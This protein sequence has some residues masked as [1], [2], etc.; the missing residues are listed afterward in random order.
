MRLPASCFQVPG[1]EVIPTI[2]FL[3]AQPC[4][5]FYCPQKSDSSFLFFCQAE[6]ITPIRNCSVDTELMDRVISLEQEFCI[7]QISIAVNGTSASP[8]L[9]DST[10]Q[11]IGTFE[12]QDD[13]SL[14]IAVPFC[15]LY[16]STVLSGHGNR[17]T[18]FLPIL[19]P[20]TSNVLVRTSW[21]NS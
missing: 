3:L 7:Y 18:S 11:S 8:L 9:Q 5:R 17:H 6:L 19:D 16:H 15:W 13:Q 14:W 21:R 1:S 2:L 20:E 10:T 4:S 12:R